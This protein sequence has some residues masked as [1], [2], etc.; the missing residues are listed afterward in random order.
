M[1]NVRGQASDES[2]ANNQ[3]QMDSNGSLIRETRPMCLDSLPRKQPRET[4]E[5][6]EVGI[7]SMYLLLYLCFVGQMIISFRYLIW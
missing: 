4:S 7:P 3:T 2:A 6:L 5:M 1:S